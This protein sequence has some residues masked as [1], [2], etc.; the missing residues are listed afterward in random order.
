MSK[1]KNRAT[2]AQKQLTSTKKPNF[3][4]C[5]KKKVTSPQTNWTV[6]HV[7]KKKKKKSRKMY[8]KRQ[9]AD[10]WLSFPVAATWSQNGADQSNARKKKSVRK[11]D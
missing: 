6:K 3:T 8:R 7:I 5:E 1:N 11:I 10:D 2:K 4:D 9:R